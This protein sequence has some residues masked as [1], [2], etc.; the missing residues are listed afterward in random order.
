MDLFFFYVYFEGIVIPM[1]FL[2]VFEVAVIVKFMHLINFL[3]IPY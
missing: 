3:Y 2:I 1:F